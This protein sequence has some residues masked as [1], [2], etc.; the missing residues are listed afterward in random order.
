MEPVG[1]FGIIEESRR[2]I[3]AYSRHFL[4]L[5]VL[6][7]LPIAFLTCAASTFRNWININ[8]GHEELLSSA[9]PYFYP[10]NIHD[11]LFTHSVHSDAM[12]TKVILLL[13]L[14]AAVIFGLALC[15][16]AAV[17][18]SICNGF[19]GRAVKL[20]GAI[21]SV[22]GSVWRLVFT[23][24]CA[25]G[26]LAG[27]SAAFG[28]FSYLVIVGLSAFNV[29]VPSSTPIYITMWIVVGLLVIYLQIHWI[30]ASVIPVLEGS[31]GLEPLRRSTYLVKGMRRVAFFLNLFF[32]I[33]GLVLALWANYLQ[34]SASDSLDLLS[35]IVQS[36]TVLAA[37]TILFLYNIATNTVFYM[38]CKAYHN[39][40][41]GAIVEEFAQ[42]YMSLPF[43]DQKVPQ[44]IT[45]AEP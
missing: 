19:F 15:S 1:F 24:L 28:L 5:S 10:R 14:Y 12:E 22:P 3:S 4:G 13:I 32:G 30:L 6:F 34:S 7:L 27:L 38:Y 45:V 25:I 21:K 8:E 44:V 37:M 35:K 16:N 23:A 17:T 31:W 20:P 2:I 29:Q 26:V 18:H 43:D 9:R 39:E 41:L 36:I 11:T 33:S 40:L 42:D